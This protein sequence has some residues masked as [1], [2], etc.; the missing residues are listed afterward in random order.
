MQTWKRNLAAIWLAQFFSIMG[1]TFAIPF[2]AFFLQELGVTD[3][4]ELANWVTMFVGA[5]PL[6]LALFAPIWG[7]LADRFG[8][9]IMMLR[10]YA[11]GF[12]VLFLRG[13]A[14]TPLQLVI[15]RL[16]QGVFTGTI[17]AA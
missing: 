6:S 9:R 12:I 15:L 11:A 8:R 4:D 7:H 3:L 17:A 1:F 2:N 14:Q 5:T 16:L 10:A 13:F